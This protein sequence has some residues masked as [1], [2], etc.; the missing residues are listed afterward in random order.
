ML[1]NG[2]LA[3]AEIALVAFRRTRIQALVEEG[4]RAAKAAKSLRSNPERFL[5]TVQIGITV[6]GASAGAFG[7]A[8]IASDLAPLV[9]QVPVLA[10]SAEQLALALVIGLISYLSLVLGEL[11]PKSLALRAAEGYA[12]LISRPLLALSWLA[13]PLVWFLT[14]S[15]NAV[16]RLFGDKTT[17]T[18]A[19]LSREELAQL[20][21]DA[22]KTGALH[23]EAGEIAARALDLSDLTAED[24]MV[25]RTRVISVPRGASPEEIQRIMLEH[26]HTRMPVYDGSIDNVV[27]YFSTKD[28]L[29][30]AWES[31]EL[32]LDDILRPAYFVP[33]LMPA[34]TLIQEMRHRRV[35]FAVAVDEQG[36]MAG[37]VTMEDLVEELVGDI[38]S[39]HDPR[40][41]ELIRREP[42]GSALVNGATPI[43]DV[44]R[45][46]DLDLPEE[47]EWTTTAGLCLALAGRIPTTGETLTSPDGSTIEVVDAS[48]RRVR[49]VRIRKQRTP[50]GR[51]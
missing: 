4:N 32:V 7:G 31:T 36:G 20:V 26:G 3:G 45:A 1:A 35:P 11:V 27:G 10:G 2:V 17:F 18:E 8:S 5:A 23:P 47:G 37:I 43:R 21:E 29:A 39:E 49:A 14:A 16:L 38:F 25:P 41:H 19:R 44:N 51:S 9:R 13:R 24:V 12:L 15:S 30:K 28:V 42:D 34:V 46:L 48:P 40:G 33:E 50:K 6:I 22:T